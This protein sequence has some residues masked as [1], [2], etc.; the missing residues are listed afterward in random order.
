V[1]NAVET[2]DGD[3]GAEAYQIDQFIV[4]PVIVASLLLILL[5]VLLV[6]YCKGKGKRGCK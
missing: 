5:I 1:E 3:V 4:A 6:K 2:S